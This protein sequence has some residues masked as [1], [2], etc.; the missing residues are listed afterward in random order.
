MNPQ[1]LHD[2]A[3]PLT[4][5][6]STSTSL[7]LGCL[8]QQHGRL[9]NMTP[10][11]ESLPFAGCILYASDYT[12]VIHSLKQCIT[13]SVRYNPRECLTGAMLVR[14]LRL[15]TA[16]LALLHPAMTGLVPTESLQHTR[17]AG[18]WCLPLTATQSCA[19]ARRTQP[20][21]TP[22][23][24]TPAPEPPRATR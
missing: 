10:L 19:A 11:N 16:A 14:K 3:L 23:G 7:S 20:S 17:A 18:P 4:W 2:A 1:V 9:S 13:T 21:A 6:T 22:G 12:V 5:Q 8:C 24:S 15:A